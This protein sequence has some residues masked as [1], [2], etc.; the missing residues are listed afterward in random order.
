[1]LEQK[2]GR[3]AY[4]TELTDDQGQA[5]VTLPEVVKSQLIAEY[6]DTTEPLNLVAITD[7]A[8]DIRLRLLTIFGFMVPLI[9]DWY[10]LGKKVRELMSMIALSKADK[11]THLQNLF[12]FLW[13]GLT[14][15][16][17]TYLKTN[18]QAKNEL[19]RLELIGYLEKHQTEIIDYRRR[20]QAGKAIGSGRV[21]KACDQVVGHRQKHK[22]MSWSQLGSH[23]LAILRTVELNQRWQQL[24]AAHS[25]AC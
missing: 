6:G 3:F 5:L 18:V 15:E 17:L 23:A 14:A 12:Y 11:V 22:G 19:K 13:R 9:L 16:A 21:E 8:R 1:M 7:G 24:W 4:L 20:Q 25:S 2:D 10:H